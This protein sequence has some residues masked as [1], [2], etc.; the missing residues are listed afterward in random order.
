MVY[1]RA[2]TSAMAERCLA[3]FLE[4]GFAEGAIWEVSVLAGEIMSGLGWAEC[5]CEQNS[6]QSQRRSRIEEW[7]GLLLLCVSLILAGDVLS[8]RGRK[9]RLVVDVGDFCVHCGSL[10]SWRWWNV[11]PCTDPFQL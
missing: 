6:R 7:R 9:A 10:N 5:G 3:G 11:G 8:C 1:S 4:A 2:T